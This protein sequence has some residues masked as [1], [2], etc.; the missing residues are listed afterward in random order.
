VEYIS[1]RHAATDGLELLD[2]Y[3]LLNLKVSY[4]PTEHFTID[5]AADNI[6]DTLY[7]IRKNYPMSGRSYT[8]GLTAKF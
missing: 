4:R 3:C 5:L 1:E 8:V 6:F 7:E 2:P